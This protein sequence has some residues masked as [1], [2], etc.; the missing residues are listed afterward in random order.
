MDKS[1]LSSL[2]ILLLY[3]QLAVRTI[4]IKVSSITSDAALTNCRTFG[5][6]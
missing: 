4:S 3:S 5:L 2:I 1:M 6:L